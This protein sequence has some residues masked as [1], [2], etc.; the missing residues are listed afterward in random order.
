MRQP[1]ARR[2]RRQRLALAAVAIL[3]IVMLAGAGRF[4]VVTRPLDA[5]DAIVSLA[6]HEWERLPVARA[7][8]ETHPRAIVILTRPGNVTKYTCH[9]CSGRVAWLESQ[10][11]SA[12]RIRVVNL[13]APGTRGEADAVA[14]FARDQGLRR[15]LVVTSPYH[16]RRAL[17]VFRSAVKGKGIEV[18]VQPAFATSPAQPGRWWA[19]AYD[20]WYVSY[21][22]A[23]SIYY[24]FRFGIIG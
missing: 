18:G 10:G 6:S 8:A 11:L 15:L 3:V 16:A 2:Q 7:L 17:A 1:R 14:Q 21:E 23:A 22:W 24:A 19:A 5:P 12:D 20:R 4:L 9:D 13:T